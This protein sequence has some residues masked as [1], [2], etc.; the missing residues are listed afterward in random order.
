MRFALPAALLAVLSA[1]APSP[2]VDGTEVII[3]DG[4]PITGA[5]GVTPIVEPS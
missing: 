1:C 4:T 2:V 5:A 3:Q